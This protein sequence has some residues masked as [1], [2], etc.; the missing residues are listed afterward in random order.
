MRNLTIIA[1]SVA[2]LA[3]G[4][5]GLAAA[6]GG[7]A[8]GQTDG[9]A[10]AARSTTET[11]FRCDGGKQKKVWNRIVDRPFTFGEGGFVD[12]PGAALKVAGPSRGKDTLSITFSAESQ[13]GGSSAEDNLVDWMGL[14]VLLDGSP[15]EPH[16][17]AADVMAITGSDSY[18]MHAAQ[19]CVKVGRGQHRLQV[20]TNLHDGDGDSDLAGWLDDY[21]LRVERSE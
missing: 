12:V 19:F 3:L 5:S 21:T 1:G 18:D 16:T 13:L 11:V 4:S 15:V 6:V 8:G 7:G 9:R 14:Q 2:A 17:A 10:S 20:R